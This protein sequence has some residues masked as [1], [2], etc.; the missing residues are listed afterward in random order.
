MSWSRG[1]HV[2]TLTETT[3]NLAGLPARVQRWRAKRR[4]SPMWT[5]SVAAIL[6]IMVLPII[7]VL[8]FALAP[9]NNIWP[10]L[11][12][13]V[14]F[15][16]FP[17]T[18]I[19]LIGVALAGFAISR[20]RPTAP[21][22]TPLAMA[23]I[24]CLLLALGSFSGSIGQ[25]VLLM[26]GAGVLT[27]VTGT[28]AAWLVTMYR[29]PGRAVVDR[30]L[31]IPLAMPT[32]IIAYAYV[33]LLDYAGP[34]QTAMREIFGFASARDYWFPEIRSIGGAVFV[35][36]SVLYPYVYLTARAS[37]VQQSVC[38][39]EVARTLGRTPL[40]VFWAVAL[41]LARPALVA[42]VS[43]VLMECLNDIGA[44][45][46]LGVQTL[47]ASV[48]STWLERSNLGGAAQIATV[49]LGFIAILFAAERIAR[50]SAQIHHTTGRYRS[51]P[52]QD[53]PGWKGYVASL[54]CAVPFLVGFAI[55]V[56]VLLHLAWK[57][58]GQVADSSF[59]AAAYNS[60]TLS[61][62][63]AGVAVVLALTLGY[64]RRVAPN[65]FIRPAVRLAGLGYAVPGTVLALGLLIPLAGIDNAIDSAARSL[66][67]VSTGLILSGS[68]FAL[69]I[70][71]S[72]R[73][74][75]VGLGTV[76]AG[77]ERISPNLDAAARALGETA[78][79]ALM[80]VHLPL[81][82]PALGSAGLLIFVDAMKEL[83]ATL[84]LRPFNFDTL[85]THV[86]SLAALEQFEEAAFGALTIVLV[87]L[88]P[89]LL[90]H[91]A[92]AGGR[93]GS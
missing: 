88:I 82:L 40:G 32:Y 68:I 55:P 45:E 48:Y 2:P 54:L 50:G 84:L 44:V 53:L 25:T 80:R 69:V 29:F 8:S 7:T 14:L 92:V 16:R 46:Y 90:L 51:I 66:L 81:L 43:L 5:A 85:A 41:P 12:A 4:S 70:A 11:F 73:F 21:A 20:L 19:P 3:R 78:L 18:A 79:S 64:A 63:A 6:G 87:G 52:F 28:A 65:G 74:L 72:I 10:H 9:E 62:V 91:K 27:I 76:E 71:Y 75:A 77:L 31:V 60:F 89:V 36:S 37:F 30:L 67:G 39:L 56:L 49:M 22:A 86:Y 34:L 15:G 57:S 61:A 13:N 59:Y 58:S 23:S 1:F 17:V 93:P 35:M 47:T 83:P 33:E 24:A 26:T 42:G 38:A